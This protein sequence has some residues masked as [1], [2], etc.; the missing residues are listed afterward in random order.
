MA[1]VQPLAS[2]PMLQPSQQFA[3]QALAPQPGQQ[4]R[5]LHVLRAPPQWAPPQV[6][7]QQPLSPEAG[8]EDSTARKRVVC[9]S[10][11]IAAYVVI[12]AVLQWAFNLAALE[13]AIEKVREVTHM[14]HGGPN[15]AAMMLNSIPQVGMCITIGLLVP[16]CGYLGVRQ[17]HQGLMGCFCS[18][19]ALHCCCGLASLFCLLAVIFGC[20]AAAPQ[21]EELLERCDPIQCAPKGWNHTS[22]EKIIDCLA[23]GTWKDYEPHFQ[24]A[25]K[26]PHFCPKVF[27]VCG[28]ERYQVEPADAPLPPAPAPRARSFDWSRGG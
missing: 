8:H 13:D 1:A 24:H 25:H 21:I 22:N 9:I 26:F 28:G 4:A 6:A 15:I 23:A 3:A 2:A 27:L 5:E 19:N 17:N 7:L 18:C 10:L 12:G 11:L 20:T 16:L 14:Q